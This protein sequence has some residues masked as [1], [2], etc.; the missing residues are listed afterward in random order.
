MLVER[1]IEAGVGGVPG[2][3]N[4]SAIVLL[5]SQDSEKPIADAGGNQSIHQGE[6]VDLDGGGSF[7]DQTATVDL[8]YNWSLDEIPLGSTATLDFPTMAQP[9]FVTDLSGDYVVTLTVTDEAGNVSDAGNLSDLDKAIISSEN[10]PPEAV[11]GDDQVIIVNTVANLDG[12]LSSDPDP[13]DS[14]TCSW[15]ITSAPVG[16]SA[17]LGGPSTCTPSLMPDIEGTYEVDLV[18]NDL[19]AVSAPDNVGITAISAAD[20]A[21]NILMDTSN[22][23]VDL[24]DN[25]FDAKGHRN[26]WTNL[27]AQIINFTQKGQLD[28]AVEKLDQI[29]ERVDGCALDSSPD[30]K[31][32]KEV[33]ADWIVNCA[34]QSDIYNDLIE[35]TA[36]LN[37]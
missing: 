19:F 12:T 26:A 17:A 8:V 35:A 30:P 22:F 24:P 25:S 15:T 18:V 14:V 16:S 23:I 21:S 34:D 27:I 6:T 4:P 1:I 29:I 7:D 5:Q 2:T 32:D 9:S 10:A 20:F 11:A 3:F 28:K 36:A 33:A 13:E 37:S 31:G